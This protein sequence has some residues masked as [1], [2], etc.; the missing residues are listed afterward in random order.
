MILHARCSDCRVWP[1]GFLDATSR[2][3]PM[4]YAFGSPYTLQ[5]SSPSADLKRHVRYGHFNMDM[6][7]ATGAGGVPFNS[8]ALSGVEMVGSMQKDAD[9]KTFAHALLGCVVL[10]AV[11]PINQLIAGFLK[12]IRIHVV[13]SLALIVC[14]GVVYGLGIAT[15]NQYNRVSPPP[16]SSNPSTHQTNTHTPSQSKT[17]STPHQ[18]LAL[19][20]LLPLLLLSLLPLPPLS[21][22]SP[23]LPRLHTPL[24]TLTLALLLLSGGLGLHLSQQTRSIILVYT[25]LSVL[26]LVFCTSLAWLIRRRGSAHARATK[27]LPLPSSAAASASELGLL[28]RETG[29]FGVGRRSES[30]TGSATSLKGFLDESR[31]DA[32]SEGQRLGSGH[33]QGQAQ[34]NMFGGGTMP[35]PQYL[36]NMHPGVPVNLGGGRTI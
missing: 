27:R 3:Q 35:G 4:M 12:N 25:A 9:V 15:S 32:G 23:L 14:L 34:R 36:L 30:E 1:N 29:K 17:Y 2:S 5:S 19:I 6:T 31:R 20:S 8:S 16:P 13:F 7:T 22:L 28:G 11:W 26:V 33:G 24:P 10:F 18:I 21:S